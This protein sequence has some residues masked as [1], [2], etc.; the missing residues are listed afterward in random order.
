MSIDST[1]T[2]E[3]VPSAPQ[4]APRSLAGDRWLAAIGAVVLIPLALFSALLTMLFGFSCTNSCSNASL[5]NS[6][7]VIGPIGSI[8]VATVA[9]IL[10]I[11]FLVQKRRAAWT[12]WAGVGGVVVVFTIC[13]FIANAG[14]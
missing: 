13:E 10:M 3:P 5:V 6:T 12:S 11:I 14:A 1:P 4:L 9:L 7:M 2:P 8:L